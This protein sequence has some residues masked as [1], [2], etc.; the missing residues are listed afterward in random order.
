MILNYSN[1]NKLN[2]NSPKRVMSS[3]LARLALHIW[4]NSISKLKVCWSQ[5]L[6]T[7]NSLTRSRRLLDP[8]KT[9]I[10]LEGIIWMLG[11][12][13]WV[14][15]SELTGFLEF[16]NVNV[17]VLIYSSY[18][19]YT[20]I[21]PLVCKWYEIK[22]NDDWGILYDILMIG[23]HMSLFYHLYPV[24]E[25]SFAFYIIYIIKLSWIHYLLRFFIICLIRNII[26]R[27]FYI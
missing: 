10:L 8:L 9:G 18:D 21:N 19:V 7:R 25:I 15:I 13:F 5:I 17:Q 22:K 16:D 11:F 24:A 3:S 4:S 23:S 12:L 26:Q 6:R 2:C 20:F 27:W 1:L 14:R